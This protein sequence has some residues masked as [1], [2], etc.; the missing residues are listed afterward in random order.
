[1][2]SNP[3]LPR[4]N[5]VLSHWAKDT[6]LH[7]LTHSL[8]HSLTHSDSPDDI[9]HYGLARKHKILVE[10]ERQQQKAKYA[11]IKKWKA[12]KNLSVNLQLLFSNKNWLELFHKNGWERCLMS[13]PILLQTLR[14]TLEPYVENSIIL[15]GFIVT[16]M[17]WCV[18]WSG[19]WVKQ[20]IRCT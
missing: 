12:W 7:S 16:Y 5:P 10:K 9:V 14:R 19:Q 2:I 3:G 15:S 1:M 18:K 17:S 20:A 11:K 13:S 4:E 6:V 8:A